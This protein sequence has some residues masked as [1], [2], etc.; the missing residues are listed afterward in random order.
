LPATGGR[1]DLIDEGMFVAY[2]RGV[3]Q[4]GLQPPPPG[5]EG[6]DREQIAIGFE[7]PDATSNGQQVVPIPTL[8]RRY[9]LSSGSRALFPVFVRAV[10][11]HDVDKVPA[12]DLLGKPVVVNVTHA[13]R[14]DGSV[15]A[16]IGTVARCTQTKNLPESTLDRFVFPGDVHYKD[17]PPWAREA[18]ANASHRKTS[19]EPDDDDTDADVPQ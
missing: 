17:L 18:I 19:S 10:L 6:I 5:S 9:S 1:D 12:R 4:L 2:V 13:P 15:S 8:Y 11:G 7:I 16:R 14:S 3:I